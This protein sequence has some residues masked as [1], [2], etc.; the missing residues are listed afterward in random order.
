MGE[1][2]VLFVALGLALIGGALPLISRRVPPG[3]R[4]GLRVRETL[5]F[6][7]V[8]YEVNACAGKWLLVTGVITLVA[9]VLLPFLFDEREN[10]GSTY[11]LSCLV[12]TV[13]GLV[14]T[15]VQAMRRIRRLVPN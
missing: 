8:W 4:Y 5:Y 7:E 10:P 9:A 14:A 15:L 3:S 6:P 12:V 13:L 1:F 11:A 2:V